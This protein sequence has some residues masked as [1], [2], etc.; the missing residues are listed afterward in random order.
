MLAA[1]GHL[2]S[3]LRITSRAITI[4]EKLSIMPKLNLNPEPKTTQKT[5]TIREKQ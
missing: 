1:A 5:L 2:K 4:V 3:L